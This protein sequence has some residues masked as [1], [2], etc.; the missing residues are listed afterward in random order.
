MKK[1]LILLFSLAVA[2]SASAQ[3]APVDLNLAAEVW[4]ST[5]SQDSLQSINT[6]TN[7]LAS[8]KTLALQQ[9]LAQESARRG[10]TERVDVRRSLEEAR[11]NVI[12]E[13]LRNDVVKSAATPTEEEIGTAYERL[14]GQLVVPEALSL[15]VFSIAGTESGKV[16]DA[17]T[18]LTDSADAAAEKLV[19]EGFKHVTADIEEPWFNATQMTTNIWSALQDMGDGAVD[20]FPDGANVLVIRKISERDSRTMTLDE[21]RDIVR[22]QLL[23]ERQDRLWNIYQRETL[24]KLGL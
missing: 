4:R 12:I 6:T 2:G 10:L 20:S 15:D 9:E 5:M 13:A 7:L 24:Q 8:Y 17:V 11:R 22:N 14:S 16:S 3:T 23:R 21:S 1:S 19:S 18:L